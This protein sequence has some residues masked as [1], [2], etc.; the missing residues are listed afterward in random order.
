MTALLAPVL[1]GTSNGVVT[2]L[3]PYTYPSTERKKSQ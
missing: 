3:R 2:A 1:D